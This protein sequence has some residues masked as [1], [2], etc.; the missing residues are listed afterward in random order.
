MVVVGPTISFSLGE[1]GPAALAVILLLFIITII[2][3]ISSF[4]GRWFII[5]ASERGLSADKR[6]RCTKL[7]GISFF[8]LAFDF[9]FLGILT[10][11]GNLEPWG[12]GVIAI[13]MPII[14]SIVAYVYY[15]ISRK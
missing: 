12:M 5:Y 3:G 6:Q 15:L 9:L 10:A 1:G 14:F 13:T 2:I 11:T 8:I 4:K 7:W